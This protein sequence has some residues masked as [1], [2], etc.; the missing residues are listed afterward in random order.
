MNIND[1]DVPLYF[2]A[3]T[4]KNY[5]RMKVYGLIPK[6]LEYRIKLNDDSSMINEF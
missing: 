6:P 3:Y 1:T 4:K 2:N 5:I